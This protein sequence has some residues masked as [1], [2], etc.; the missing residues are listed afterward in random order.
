[1]YSFQTNIYLCISIHNSCKH[2]LTYV[3]IYIHIEKRNLN[4]SQ[5]AQPGSFNQ[6]SHCEPN[7]LI[8]LQVENPIQSVYVLINFYIYTYIMCVMFI[9]RDEPTFSLE[10]SLAVTKYFSCLVIFRCWRILQLTSSLTPSIHQ[11]LNRTF[12]YVNI[13]LGQSE[14][15]NESLQSFTL[16]AS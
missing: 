13:W 12:V 6:H 16:L 9:L 11:K 14:N 8:K 5:I 7:K 2:T 15:N 10:H 1:M 4:Y 3:C